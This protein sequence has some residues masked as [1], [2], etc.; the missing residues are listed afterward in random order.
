[1]YSSQISDLISS[2]IIYLCSFVLFF[3]QCMNRGLDRAAE[4]TLRKEGNKK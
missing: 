4:A 2:I 1:M 3:K